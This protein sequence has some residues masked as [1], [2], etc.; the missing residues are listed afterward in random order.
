MFG[1]GREQ[2][3]DKTTKPV[4]SV[5]CGKIQASIWRNETKHGP[6][7]NVTVC[8]LYHE[9]GEWKRSDSFGR[10]EVLT[11]ARALQASFD[12]MWTQENQPEEGNED[13]KE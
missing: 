10:E 12:W 13:G 11:A 5:K 8:R 1:L 3:R 9:N 2:M 4:H 7:F 6:R